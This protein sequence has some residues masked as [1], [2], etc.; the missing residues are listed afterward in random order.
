MSAEYVKNDSKIRENRFF[1]KY[2]QAEGKN[3][4]I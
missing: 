4:L 3:Q 2:Y 1:L